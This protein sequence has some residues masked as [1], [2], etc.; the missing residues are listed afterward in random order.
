[1]CIIIT[2]VGYNENFKQSKDRVTMLVSKV[3]VPGLIPGIVSSI[4]VYRLDCILTCSMII[5]HI[6]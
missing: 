4:P 1:M 2:M 5:M 6:V 3:I